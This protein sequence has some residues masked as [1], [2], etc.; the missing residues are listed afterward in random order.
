MAL[1]RLALTPHTLLPSGAYGRQLHPSAPFSSTKQA[2]R[3]ETAT[4]V[5][6]SRLVLLQKNKSPCSLERASLGG[7]V[8]VKLYS[9]LGE[10]NASQPRSGE[11]H[12]QP[13]SSLAQ[14]CFTPVGKK[15]IAQPRCGLT[16]PFAQ[17][18]A[19]QC[20]HRSMPICIAYSRVRVRA[21]NLPA[22]ALLQIR[23]YAIRG[24]SSKLW[25]NFIQHGKSLRK[26]LKERAAGPIG[27]RSLAPHRR[28]H[29]LCRRD[30]QAHHRFLRRARSAVD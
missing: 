10:G 23:C 30:R 9:E 27:G 14:P 17:F 26:N 20:H 18:L 25:T 3:E 1:L 24:L 2:T 4:S 13:P 28:V 29:D 22:Q 16:L 7:H 5:Q 12:N 6:A 11:A 21:S 8:A 19:R 15:C